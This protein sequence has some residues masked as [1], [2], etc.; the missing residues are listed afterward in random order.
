[1]KTINHK[2]HLQ[3]HQLPFTVRS[4][5]IVVSYMTMRWF[6]KQLVKKWVS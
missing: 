6:L 5:K 1:M 4:S 3:L 2:A